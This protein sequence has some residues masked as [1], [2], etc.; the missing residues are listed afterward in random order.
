MKKQQIVITMRIETGE[1]FDLV[2][3]IEI[4][5]TKEPLLKIKARI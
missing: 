1:T 3:E 2:Q 4:D 5:G